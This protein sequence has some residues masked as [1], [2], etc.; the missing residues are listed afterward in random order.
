LPCRRRTNP[1]GLRHEL[2]GGKS[3]TADEPRGALRHRTEQIAEPLSA[4]RLGLVHEEPLDGV[5]RGVRPSGK[6]RPKRNFA[7]LDLP[8]ARLLLAP[9]LATCLDP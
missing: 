8:L 5:N 2:Q 9:P 3:L 7:S 4:R 1:I 6:R